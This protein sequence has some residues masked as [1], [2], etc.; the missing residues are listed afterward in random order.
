VKEGSL[1]FVP[2]GASNYSWRF[3]TGEDGDSWP[4]VATREDLTEEG[5][6]LVASLERLY[7]L[8]VELVTFIDT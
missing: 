3:Y 6:S 7:G 8:P 4:F 2:L 5:K 1:A